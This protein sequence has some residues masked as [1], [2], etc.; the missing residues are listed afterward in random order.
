MEEKLSRQEEIRKW[1]TSRSL[2]SFP[3]TRDRDA[4]HLRLSFS[5][6]SP[7]LWNRNYFLRFRFRLLKSSGSDSDF[8]KLRFWFRFTRQ[9]VTVPV[10]FHNT[11]DPIM[12]FILTMSTLLEHTLDLQCYTVQLVI[13]GL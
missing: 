11:S 7:V 12:L 6:R 5:Y 3:W 1:E 2:S 9:K 10:W 13:Y 4:V 8:G